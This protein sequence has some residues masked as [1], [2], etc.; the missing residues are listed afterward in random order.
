[1]GSFEFT[2]F[3][4]LVNFD[5]NQEA[6]RTRPSWARFWLP[7]CLKN[8]K[9]HNF[10]HRFLFALVLSV[11]RQGFIAFL[12]TLAAAGAKEAVTHLQIESIDDIQRHT[13]HSFYAYYRIG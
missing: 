13:A 4:C 7:F 5:K 1:M 6:C 10:C 8:C 3:D 2:L 11:K 12:L 9:S